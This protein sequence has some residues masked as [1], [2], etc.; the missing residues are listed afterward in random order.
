M[1]SAWSSPR[2]RNEG[3]GVCCL[4]LAIAISGL[5]SL[6]EAPDSEASLY[7]GYDRVLASYVDSRGRVDYASLKDE[8]RGLDLFVDQ[9]RDVDLTTW[10]PASRIAFW[11]NAYNALTLRVIIDNYP[12][13]SRFLASLAYPENSIRQ[14]NG[15]WDEIHFAVAGR[16][17]TLDQ[18]EHSILREQFDEPRMHVALVCAALGCP[19]L[20][21]EAYRGELLENQLQDQAAQFVRDDSRFRVDIDSGV[22]YLSSIFNW[23]G[24]DFE[25][26]YGTAPRRF[27]RYSAA[28]GAVLNFA[29]PFL[30]EG[31]QQYL[32][33]QRFRIKYLS[34]DWTLNEQ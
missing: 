23:F 9:L 21:R 28:V 16:D 29:L 2:R 17:R 5:H 8:R 11:I 14:I 20:R 12:I 1:K 6:G 22:V 3:P 33:A 26:R 30:P 10:N 7:R 18:I 34:Y 19:F 13:Q 32:Q 24:R 15:A 31:S 27:P 4:I 25:S